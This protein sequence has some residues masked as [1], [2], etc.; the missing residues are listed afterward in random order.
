MT[1]I[2]AHVRRVCINNG[3]RFRNNDA[4]LRKLPNGSLQWGTLGSEY[5]MVNAS[6]EFRKTPKKMV[7]TP[8]VRQFRSSTYRLVKWELTSRRK[9]SDSEK[10][11]IDSEPRAGERVKV[12]TFS[13]NEKSHVRKFWNRNNDDIVFQREITP[14]DSPFRSPKTRAR[15]KRFVAHVAICTAPYGAQR[16]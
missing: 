13:L 15:E 4:I 7:V 6:G 11:K 12:L 2:K 1:N 16:R 10:M 14:H 5:R 8:S 9:R 3:E